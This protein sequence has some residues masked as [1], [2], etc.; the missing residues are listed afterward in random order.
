MAELAA[1][2]TAIA[3]A[4]ATVPAWVPTAASV[5]ATA[6]GGAMAYGGARR[7]AAMSKAAGEY[8]AQ[9]LEQAA[10]QE[11]AD[12]SRK[13]YERQKQGERLMSRQRAVAA[14]GGAGAGD[15]E[16]FADVIGD[17][18]GYTALQS[19]LE[20]GLGENRARGLE[21]KAAV[22]RAK[23]GAEAD[24]Y[25]AK[26]T[27]ALIGAGLDIA[28]TGLKRAPTAAGG[29]DLIYEEYGDMTNR[30]WHTTGR[31]ATPRRRYG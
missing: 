15:T 17:T 12:A 28:A 10:G 23:G 21:S 7:Q 27:S 24:L 8:N 3:G 5:A 26:G 4:A 31:S 1:I 9:G 2:G 14:A 22:S 13:A 30:G 20:I 29:D 11:R 25:S 6:A 16:G 19:A 18:A